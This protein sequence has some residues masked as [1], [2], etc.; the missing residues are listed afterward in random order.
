MAPEITAYNGAQ[1]LVKQ[2]LRH[3]PSYTGYPEVVVE[4][5]DGGIPDVTKKA[6]HQLIQDLKLVKGHVLIHCA[7]GHG[8][9]GT[10]LAILVSL[11]KI[12]TGDPVTWVREQYC[13]KTIETEKQMTYLKEVIHIKTK[14]TPRYMSSVPMTGLNSD[15]PGQLSPSLRT[16]APIGPWWVRE[17][18]ALTEP[19]NLSGLYRCN[20]CMRHK[21][22]DLMSHCNAEGIGCCYVCSGETDHFL[23][24]Y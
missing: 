22:R 13:G 4:W 8:R 18:Q 21:T 16:E 5:P 9:T 3:A 23:E 19:E 20:V 24:R 15:I 2:F 6:W 1:K 7:G 17:T 11:G 10:L 14:A 12:T